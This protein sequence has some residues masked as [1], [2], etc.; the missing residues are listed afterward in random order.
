[1]KYE[2]LLM[3]VVTAVIIHV[4]DFTKYTILA[5][6]NERHLLL[7]NAA[8]IKGILLSLC[9]QRAILNSPNWHRILIFLLECS[10]R[11]P[12]LPNGINCNNK[13]NL[14]TTNILFC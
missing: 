11:L 2:H 10:L 3:I 14:F 6:L 8:I 9:L 12:L 4:R 5:I 1:M 7:K 13:I